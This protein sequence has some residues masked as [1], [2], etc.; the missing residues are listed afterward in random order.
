MVALVMRYKPCLLPRGSGFQNEEVLHNINNNRNLLN[1]AY[2]LDLY[3]VIRLQNYIHYSNG[4]I[5]IY[6]DVVHFL[7][8]I[9]LSTRNFCAE[10]PRVRLIIDHVTCDLMRNMSLE[11]GN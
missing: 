6:F 11:Q 10:I 4:I 5:S 9:L 1:F 8:D 2:P 7:Y 3:T